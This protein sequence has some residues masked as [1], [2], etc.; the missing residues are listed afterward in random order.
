MKY[1]PS[2][3]LRSELKAAG[4][5]G[6]EVNELRA[7]AASLK[8]LKGS[9]KPLPKPAARY[10]RPSRWQTILPAGLIT[11]AGVAFGMALVIFSQTVLPGSWLY[12]VQKL[13][14]NATA[15]IHPEYRG[16]IMMRRAQQVKE[17]VAEHAGSSSV[18]KALADYRTE[19]SAYKSTAT[20]YAV[21]EYCK[22]SLRQAAAI[23]PDPQKQAINDA[24]SSLSSA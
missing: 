22:T 21:F 6:R 9:S 24:L 7:L 13:S 5:H 4:A 16:T 8:G 14:D 1:Q 17:L 3:A 23:A 11:L 18:L 19:A 20:N 10:R 2:D 12:P 15:A